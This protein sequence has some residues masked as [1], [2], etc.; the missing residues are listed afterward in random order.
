MRF[1]IG[2]VRSDVSHPIGFAEDWRL[3]GLSKLAA[4]SLLRL[5]F[6]LCVNWLPGFTQLALTYLEVDCSSTALYGVLD[7]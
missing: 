5:R 3:D 6:Y 7:F 1:A 2:R 4:I